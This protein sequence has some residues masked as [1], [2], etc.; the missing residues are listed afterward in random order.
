MSLVPKCLLS[1][2]EK[3]FKIVTVWIVGIYMIIS[4]PEARLVHFITSSGSSWGLFSGLRVAKEDKHTN[5]K[6]R[7]IIKHEQAQ[8]STSVSKYLSQFL[9]NLIHSCVACF[10]IA[11]GKFT[12]SPFWAYI[13]TSSSC[14]ILIYSHRQGVFASISKTR[15]YV[16]G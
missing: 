13:D 10:K 15:R 3:I 4:T 14:R 11:S 9:S 16:P 1:L 5:L 12:S 2:S 8:L 6:R 7:R